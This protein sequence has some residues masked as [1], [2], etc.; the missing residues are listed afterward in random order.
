M[1]LVIIVHLKYGIVHIVRNIQQWLSS[2][3]LKIKIMITRK[4]NISLTHKNTSGTLGYMVKSKD[5]LL[6]QES[7]I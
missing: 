5:E 1:G 4:N 3:E 6:A 2:Y 7:D